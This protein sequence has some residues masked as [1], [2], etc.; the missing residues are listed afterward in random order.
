[1]QEKRTQWSTLSKTSGIYYICVCKYKGGGAERAGRCS[2]GAG[3]GVASSLLATRSDKPRPASSSH[4]RF[5]RRRIRGLCLGLDTTSP[6]EPRFRSI[7]SS[8]RHGR[9]VRRRHVPAGPRVARACPPGLVPILPGL[10]F[11]LRPE[12]RR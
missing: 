9:S 4:L 8:S 7:T 3:L 12:E 11:L 2:R 6:L 10:V 5:S 1:M